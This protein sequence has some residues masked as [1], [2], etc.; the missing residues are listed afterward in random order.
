M[1]LVLTLKNPQDAVAVRT[2]NPQAIKISEDR[3]AIQPS[4]AADTIKHLLSGDVK[5]E[6]V[7]Q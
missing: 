1:R 2:A 5:F 7:N 6:F 3:F 4:M